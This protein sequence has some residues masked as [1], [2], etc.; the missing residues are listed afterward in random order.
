MW[1]RGVLAC[2]ALCA[3]ARAWPGGAV[4]AR[5]VA[6]AG[7]AR[8]VAFLGGGPGPAALVEAAWGA[9]GRIRACWT[10]R[11]PRL[12]RAFLAACVRRAPA[13]PGA[14]LRR[15][16]AALWRRRAGCAD[17][18]PVGSPRRRPRGW[19]LP[20]TLWCGA[21][22]SAGHSGELGLFR[23]PDRC[24]REHDQCSAQIAALQFSY[25]V[26]NYRL[27]TV[28][29][30]DCDARF[31][32]CLLAL[33]DTIS[34]IIG[35]TFFNVLEVPC[36]VLEESEQCVQWHWWGGCE[37]YDVV[38][39]ARM[40]QQSQYRYSPLT[41]E[42]GSPVVQPS[43]KGAKPSRAGRKRLQQG[44]VQN[45]GLRR[46]W[47]PATAQQLRGPSTLSSASTR[48]KAE[49]TTRH[50]A[51]QRELE[52]GPPTAVSVLEQDLARGRQVLGEAQLSAG[53]S[54]APASTA[55][56][57][58]GIVRPSLA[59]E[60]NRATPGPAVEG[61]RQQGLGRVCRCHKHLDKCEHQIA[62]HEVKYQL[63]N[64]DTR[65]LFHCN[66]TRRL[67]RFLRRARDISDVEVADLADRIAMGCFVLE[68]PTDCIPGEGP[69]DSCITVPRAMLVP[70]QYLKKTMRHW[71]LPHVSSK[72]KHPERKM[73][74]GGTLYEQCLRLALEQQPGTPHH[75]VPQ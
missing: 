18:E 4:C 22:D 39:L 30:C 67:A 53:S 25:G 63:H 54:A 15:D 37:R 27:H 72:A 73:D 61:G 38:P 19:T 43:G 10:R 60:W 59:T 71:G 35:V 47:K 68:P 14:A 32:Q 58:N 12:A 23:G 41:E 75:T 20:G 62:P 42:A 8:Y 34:N 3:C 69:Q 24:C 56:P 29:H 2:A 70:A 31:R 66:C 26:R 46:A 7:G 11:D 6:G 51:V 17:P 28:S 16:L 44:Q 21:G 65:T 55:C 40:V 9:R 33:N 57:S 13:A 45:L 64:V 52:P 36:F 74:S 48:E 5:R 49:P 1:A 50:P